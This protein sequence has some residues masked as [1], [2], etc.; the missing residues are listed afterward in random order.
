MTRLISLRE[1]GQ[2]HSWITRK[3]KL[4]DSQLPEKKTSKEKPS[5]GKDTG[6]WL[7]AGLPALYG[8]HQ[9][10]P[11]VQILRALSHGVLEV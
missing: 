4:E 8:P 9:N 11:W 3:D 1:M 6:A 10:R 2:L 7:E 5:P